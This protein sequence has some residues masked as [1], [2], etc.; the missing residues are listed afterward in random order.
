MFSFRLDYLLEALPVMGWGML[1]VFLVTGIL[2]AAVTLLN[3]GT[4]EQ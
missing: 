3:K 2:I 4:G 1:G